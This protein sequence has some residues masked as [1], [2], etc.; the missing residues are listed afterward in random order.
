MFSYVKLANLDANA[1]D[2]Q[3]VV[4]DVILCDALF[5]VTISTCCSDFI[6]CG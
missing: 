4:L 5:K 3:T 1:P 6:N 2:P